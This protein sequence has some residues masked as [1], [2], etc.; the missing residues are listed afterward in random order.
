MRLDIRAIQYQI[1]VMQR[2]NLRGKIFPLKS[3]IT[4]D[5]IGE[6]WKASHF[7]QTNLKLQSGFTTL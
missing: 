2:G 5:R 3:P 6:R 4:V 1:W 7:A